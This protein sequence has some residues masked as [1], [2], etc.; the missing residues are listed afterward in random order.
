[1]SVPPAD[2]TGDRRRQGDRRRRPTPPLGR[3]WLRGRR[4][5]PRRAEERE[6]E[7]YVDRYS[8]KTLL[9]VLLVL[10]LSVVDA[11]LTLYLVGHGAAEIN[12]VMAHFLRF[13]P[14]AF[15]AAK[16]ALTVSSILLLLIHKNVYLFHTRL[17]AR[18][19]FYLF[20]GIFA[21]VVLWEMYLVFVLQQ[22]L[23]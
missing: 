7:Y 8:A 23:A 12:P 14:V 2:P 21:T 1:M 15:L 20:L 10:V 19:L 16:Y 11:F 22:T 3:F 6:G 18:V 5:G 4:R 17:R 13:G 9:L